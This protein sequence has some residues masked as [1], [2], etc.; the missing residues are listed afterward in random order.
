MQNLVAHQLDLLSD[1]VLMRANI[2][3]STETRLENN[4]KVDLDGYQC[5]MQN[6]RSTCAGGVAIYVKDT[7]CEKLSQPNL[8]ENDVG[9][10]CSADVMLFGRRTRVV[11]IYISPNTLINRIRDL[12]LNSGLLSDQLSPSCSHI[13]LHVCGDFNVNVMI[14]AKKAQ[15]LSFMAV[16]FGLSLANSSDISV[17][18]KHT[19]IDLVFVRN[20]MPVA[21][22]FNTS[23]FSYHKP[24]F[25]LPK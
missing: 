14:E 7:W 9:D 10:I 11:V 18:G 12:I 4:A 21:C 22:L 23:Y 25:V 3:C 24:M 1:S 6:K 20:V 16:E 8:S 15:L 17:T 19:C 13:P 2:L 5:L